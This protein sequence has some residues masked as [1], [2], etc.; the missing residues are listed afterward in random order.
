[1]KFTIET[2]YLVPEEYIGTDAKEA[3]YETI[4]EKIVDGEH[5]KLRLISEMFA[6]NDRQERRNQLRYLYQNIK[7][8]IQKEQFPQDTVHCK[9]TTV[10]GITRN[11]SPYYPEHAEETLFE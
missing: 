11:H 10:D 1:M 6:D 4:L 7:E 9:S 5:K 3:S 8:I 2:K